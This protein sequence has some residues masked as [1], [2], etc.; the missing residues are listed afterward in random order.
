GYMVDKLMDSTGFYDWLSRQNVLAEDEAISYLFYNKLDPAVCI[1]ECPYRVFKECQNLPKRLD[2]IGDPMHLDQTDSTVPEISAQGLWADLH[3]KDPP[4]I[5]DVREPREYKAGH[6]SE[7]L[8]IPLPEIICGS[9]HIDREQPIVFVC[10]SGR[11]SKRVA[12]ML[13]DQ[14]YENIRILKGGMLVW[15]AANLLEA[16]DL[17]H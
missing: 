7:A 6:I 3:G 13:V 11:R 17:V 4:Q 8:S 2:L 15:E 9:T 14:G 5:I 12:G 10:R 1:Y 16:V